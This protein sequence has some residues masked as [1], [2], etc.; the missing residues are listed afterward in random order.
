VAKDSQY[1]MLLS[2][3]EFGVDALLKETPFERNPPWAHPKGQ[4]E[5]KEIPSY[6]FKGG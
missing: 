6:P 1:M 3:F 2:P 4:Q 5:E